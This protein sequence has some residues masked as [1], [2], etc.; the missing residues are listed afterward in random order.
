[1]TLVPSSFGLDSML[2]GPSRLCK[3]IKG[4][5]ST[6]QK[7]KCFVA[8]PLLPGSFDVVVI[9]GGHAGAEACAASART[10]ARTVLVTPSLENLGTCSCN[11][12]FGGIGK[13]TMIREVDALDGLAGRVIDK[14]GVTF[15]I[16]NRSKAQAVWV[17]SY[18]EVL[19]R[20]GHGRLGVVGN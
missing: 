13:G 11:P 17:S 2:A 10:G 19:S 4:A 18:L 8:N 15:T 16:L 12:S 3:Q 9:G 14:A 1:M 7:H 20:V 6:R 5:D